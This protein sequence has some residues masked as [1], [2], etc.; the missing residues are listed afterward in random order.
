MGK[1]KSHGHKDSVKNIP[2][3]KLF[4]G[5]LHSHTSFSTGK[6]TPKDAFLYAK[7]K[8]LDFLAV[9]DH[10]AFLHK[11]LEERHKISTRWLKTKAMTKKINKTHKSFV[12]LAGF[13]CKINSVGHINIYNSE[14]LPE[15]NFK[16]I[17]NLI[18]WLNQNDKSIVC[19]NHPH[20]Q[21]KKLLKHPSLQKNLTL[22]E[23]GNGAS[24]N[25]YERFYEIYFEF[26]DNGWKLGAVIGQDN[27]RD[28]WG[29]DEKFTVIM[30]ENFSSSAFSDAL[31][32]RRT[33]ASESRTLKL[34][35]LIND[36]FMGETLSCS[37]NET[38]DLNVKLEDPRIPIEQV[39]LITNKGITLKKYE[40]ENQHQVA[41]N[42]P[43]KNK[44]E[45]TWYA[46]IIEQ[47][48]NRLSI[49]SPIFIKK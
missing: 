10:L 11:T 6:G 1:H 7:E 3:F 41:I 49:S 44:P 2:L 42:F 47:P 38:L 33:F 31:K 26:L 15:K 28:N 24:P 13:E 9:T 34:N 19:I 23:V 5:V 12:S 37:S 8:K 14:K 35:F 46:V 30:S 16:S 17:D 18:S 4:Y 25:K 22:M 27:H 32:Y 21:I 20:N 40:I 36:A 39:I 29:D 45:E 43:F 48:G